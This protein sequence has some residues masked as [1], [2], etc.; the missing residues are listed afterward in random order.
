MSSR[1]LSNNGSSSR[2]TGSSTSRGLEVFVVAIARLAANS[3][4]GISKGYLRSETWRKMDRLLDLIELKSGDQAW[5]A[6][7]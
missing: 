7:V 3:S 6:R 4:G 2:R 1:R 5:L